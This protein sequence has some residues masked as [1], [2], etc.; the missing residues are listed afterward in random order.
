MSGTDSGLFQPLNA[1]TRSQLATVLYQMAGAPGAAGAAGFTDV[2]EDKWYASAV[3]WASGQ[4]VMTG[5]ES[6][7]FGPEDYVT[8]EQLASIFWRFAGSP[9]GQDADFDDS[10]SIRGYAV[11]AVNWAVSG[12]LMRAQ[13]GNDFV[14][15]AL[16]TR[17]DV[18]A[19]IAGYMG[20]GAAAPDTTGNT[21]SVRASR[22]GSASAM[23]IM[24]RPCGTTVTEEGSLLITDVYNKVIWEVRGD[25]TT[26]FAGKITAEDVRGEPIGGY[27]DSTW[28][29]SLFKKPWDIVYFL[30]GWAVSDTENDVVRFLRISAA[31]GGCTAVTDLGIPFEG[32]TG[33]AVDDDG[34]LYVAET[35]GGRVRM[36]NAEGKS[37]TIASGLE[38]PTGLC[39]AGGSLYIA[40]S[41]N[42]RVLKV[43][44]NREQTVVA[45]SGRMGTTDGAA[46]S[47][48]FAGPK[49]VAVAGDGTVYVADTDNGAVRKIQDG[50]VSTILKRDPGDTTSAYPASP[51]GLEIVGNTLYVTDTFA[52]KLLAVP[53]S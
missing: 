51:T 11:P 49:G 24:G 28:A 5:Y 47:A 33:L 34:N 53:L 48:A 45:G 39:W 22:G 32:P 40:E 52:G 30:G 16:A 46:G 1:L 9:E 23:E 4:G 14:P 35:D 25:D 15:Q 41:G 38:A 43:D 17:A 2:R 10:A 26:L 27:H 50:Q 29:E 13:S 18:A 19:A 31:E 7:G 36:F 20:G 37:T 42:N 21:P 3:N 6:G 12:G 8:R 44:E